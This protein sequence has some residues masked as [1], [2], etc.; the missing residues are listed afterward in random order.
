MEDDVNIGAQSL[1]NAH[2]VHVEDVINHLD[3]IQ[4]LRAEMEA[5]KKCHVK[6]IE[7]LRQQ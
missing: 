1:N 7:T 5:M 6:E 3:A 4:E 2:F